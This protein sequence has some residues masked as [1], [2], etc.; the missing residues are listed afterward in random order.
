MDDAE[1]GG[2]VD[3]APVT[4]AVSDA[5][6]GLVSLA[7][8]GR[9]VAVSVTWLTDVA[10]AATGAWTWRDTGWPVGTGIVH[11]TGLAPGLQTA[12]SLVVNA[13]VTLAWSP[14]VT[15]SG[16]VQFL[17]DTCTVNV[18]VWPRWMPLAGRV[19]LM[20]SAGAGAGLDEDGLGDELAAGVAKNALRV[21]VWAVWA[22]F[23]VFGWAELGFVE[24]ESG[25]AEVFVVAGDCAG[26][27]DDAALLAEDDDAEDV[28]VVGGVGVVGVG[29]GV[30]GE[31]AATG[32]QL[33]LVAGLAAPVI[34]AASATP[35]VPSVP[36]AVPSVSRTPPLTTP[37]AIA[38][39][40]TKHMEDCPVC[41][42]RQVNRA[43]SDA[44]TT[45]SRW[46]RSH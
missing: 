14:T 45:R 9:A 10:E 21:A 43:Y 44:G 27:L 26:V 19:R 6:S 33:L 25:V 39:M 17:L 28:G 12:P 37:A 30:P 2:L 3:G 7:V 41:P 36:S 22:G 13:G 8:A 38:R 31:E 4:W 46:F 40:C 1:E 24:L 16:S 18:P 11:S 5:D 23:V 35:W 20:H 32:T 42:A 29:V 34:V 15:V